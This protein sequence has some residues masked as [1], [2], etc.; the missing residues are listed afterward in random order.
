MNF[1]YKKI[2]VLI[3]ISLL[4]FLL[5][6]CKDL[7]TQSI[8]IKP[9]SVLSWITTD[10]TKPTLYIY[11][12]TYLGVGASYNYDD[13]FINYAKVNITDENNITYN[14][15]PGE[16]TY[17]KNRAYLSEDTINFQAGKKYYLNIDING[18]K[19]LGE[20]TFPGDF[21]I[22]SPLNKTLKNEVK[23]IELNIKWTKSYGA[24]GY[25]IVI[26]YNTISQ[27]PSVDNKKYYGA[28]TRTFNNYDNERNFIIPA[29]YPPYSIADTTKP[30]EIKV[31]AYDKNYYMHHFAHYDRAGLDSA[32]G[33]FGSAT[34]KKV[35]LYYEGNNK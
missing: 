21:K 2:L 30:V 16:T 1:K 3:L 6:H 17:P 23:G 8:E 18:K 13:F 14:F 34:V 35:E 12:T 28:T 33:Y 31:I 10:T 4:F 7:S 22:T 19:I 27:Y 32:Y 9:V 11:K 15:I 24:L 20:T 29:P 26:T 5:Q 25:I